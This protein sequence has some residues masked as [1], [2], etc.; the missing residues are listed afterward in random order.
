[1]RDYFVRSGLAA[2]I[3]GLSIDRFNE[4]VAAGFYPCAP[5][6]RPG[7]PRLFAENDLVALC[8]YAQ[9]ISIG[10]A[11][12]EAGDL[13]CK[14]FLTIDTNMDRHAGMSVSYLGFLNADPEVW[15]DMTDDAPRRLGE[16]PIAFQFRFVIQTYRDHIQK[17]IAEAARIIGD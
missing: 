4:A 8:I 11:P 5:A 13:A 10:L 2:K 1:M 9:C 12:R 6:A 15:W 3:A 16:R 17:Q 14:I 7:S